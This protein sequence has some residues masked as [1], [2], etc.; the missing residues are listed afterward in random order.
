MCQEEAHAAGVIP[1]FVLKPIEVVIPFAASLALAASLLSF[2][3][4][5]VAGIS[6]VAAIKYALAGA[7]L[8]LAICGL[9]F[10]LRSDLQS[11][12]QRCTC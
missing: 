8:R 1:I 11:S 4:V 12:L 6:G 3:N 10:H 5:I 2:T 7:L 9:R